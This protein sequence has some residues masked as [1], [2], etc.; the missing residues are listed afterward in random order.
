MATRWN[1]LRE[2]A[3]Q[4][5]TPV[6]IYDGPRGQR[7]EIITS[8]RGAA[9]LGLVTGRREGQGQ[10]ECLKS[11]EKDR[12]VRHRSATARLTAQTRLSSQLVRLSRLGGEPKLVSKQ[13]ARPFRFFYLYWL[14]KKTINHLLRMPALRGRTANAEKKMTRYALGA[15]C[16]QRIVFCEEGSERSE[17]AGQTS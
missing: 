7:I 9:L 13:R 5:A 12:P 10:K 2:N 14:S 11:E 16:P 1:L 4:L 8:L 15:H 3:A 17:S 6:H